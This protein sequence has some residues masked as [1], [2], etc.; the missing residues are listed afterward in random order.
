GYVGSHCVRALCNAGND[1]VVYDNLTSGGHREAV[2]AR[3]SLI[4]GDLSDNELIDKTFATQQFDGVMHFAA[5]LD[6]NESVHKPL[7]YYRNNVINSVALLELMHI[8]KIGTIVF[9]SSCATYGLPPGVPIT[10]DMPQ[11]PVTPYG[12]TKLAIEWVLRD[13]AAAWGLG[14]TA[15]RY[16]NAAGAA[17]D[18]EIGEDHNPEIHLIPRVLQ[19]ALGRSDKIRVFGLDYPTPDGTCVRDYV[20]VEDLADAHLMAIQTQPDGQFRSYNVG[21]G[22]GVSVKELIEVARDVTGHDIPAA[23][24]PRREGDPPELYA[25][26]TKITNELGWQPRYGDVRRIVETAWQWHRKHPDGYAGV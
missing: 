22:V 6:V 25:D 10:E 9:S 15:L 26:P 19:V 1:V 13:S 11:I 7:L 14:A 21:T 23:P 18:A 3:A 12:R 24:A 4:V 16:F 5:F 20:H 8:H 2:D 17:A